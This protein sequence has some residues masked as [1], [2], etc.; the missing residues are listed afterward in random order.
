ME[1]MPAEEFERGYLELFWRRQ[2]HQWDNYVVGASHD[3][4]A[5]DDEIFRLVVSHKG[6]LEAPGRRGKVLRDIVARELVE[7]H[8]D[9]AR[10]R[11]RLDDRADYDHAFSAMQRS[12]PV[13]YKRLLAQRMKPDVLELMRVRQCLARDLGFP[14]YVALVLSTEGLELE[15]I[16][17]LLEEYVEE[18][19][20]TAKALIKRY[21]M[22][23]PTWFSDLDTVGRIDLDLTP[24]GVM[25]RFL[26]YL[27]FER[28]KEAIPITVQ[29]QAI[30][31]YAGILSVPDDVRILVRPIGSLK[32][33]LTLFH[34]LGHALAHA[35][36][37]QPGIFK[38]WTN[39]YGESMAVLIEHVAAFVLLDQANR[40]SARA[41]FVLENTRCAIS[42]LFELA[43]WERPEAAESLY[44]QHHSQLGLHIASP[45]VWALDS[46]RSVDPVYVH[47][48]VIGALVA[49]KTINLLVREYGRNFRQWGEWLISNYYADG[50]TRTLREKTA[51]IDAFT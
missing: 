48:Y 28:L 12:D 34:E 51:V 6:S 44:A 4:C 45:E 8:P 47:N 38:T 5:V 37:A 40:E 32:R 41:L 10:L 21:D 26:E 2:R 22:S 25:S 19:L 42:A 13:Q 39:V 1:R 31:G 9:A 43:L 14:S 20:P 24:P 7:K 17:T 35:L 16:V 11:N 23:W 36:N 18:N 30:E 15:W 3:L 27:G 50:R 29:E 33:W 46:F 49:D